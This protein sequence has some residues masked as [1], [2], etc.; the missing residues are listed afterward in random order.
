MSKISWLENFLFL[1]YPYDA[2]DEIHGFDYK[3][4]NEY[5]KDKVKYVCRGGLFGGHK[6]YISQANATYYS[7]LK[8][9]LDAGY[10][11]TE[12][13]VFSIMAHLEPHI[14]RRYAL[15]GNGLIV[16]FIQA[17]INDTVKL[18][19]VQEKKINLFRKHVNPDS[20][21]FS[22]YMLTFNFPEQVEHTIQTYLQ[23]PKWITN[24]K[25]YLIDNS[26]NEEARIRNK[27]IADRYGFY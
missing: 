17:L 5:S 14:Y 4:I 18:E 27:E 24:T 10:M 6:N 21:K 9:T 3:A 8:E 12:E 13:S 2:V 15:D 11:G 16:K 25:N 26:T 7:L 20:L 1:S 22:F 23:H 19:E